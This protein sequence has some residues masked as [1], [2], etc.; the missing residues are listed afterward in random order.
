M[1]TEYSLACSQKSTTWPCSESDGSSPHSYTL[2]IK[3][4]FIIIVPYLIRLQLY[5]L[6]LE[7]RTVALNEFL[8]SPMRMSH[9]CSLNDHPNNIC[10]IVQNYEAPY[11][12]FFQ[13][14]VT[15]VPIGA[16]IHLSTMFST[17][18]NSR[19]SSVGSVSG[20]LIIATSYRSYFPY[21]YVSFPF[22]LTLK[23]YFLGSI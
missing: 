14:A 6:S 2:I 19:I 16:N 4:H 10:W 15:S 17:T 7:V 11:Y 23:K 13:P 20:D 18:F 8:I 22:H 12:P 21:M 9:S 3:I 1:N 5:V